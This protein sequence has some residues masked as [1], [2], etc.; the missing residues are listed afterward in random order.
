MDSLL[1]DS[2]GDD[3][4]GHINPVVKI[5]GSAEDQNFDADSST[6]VKASIKNGFH[7]L[8][9]VKEGEK[10]LLNVESS[11]ETKEALMFFNTKM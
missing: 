8:P 1:G 10:R 7:L 2:V 11:Q 3:L 6:R 9:G 5:L 4:T